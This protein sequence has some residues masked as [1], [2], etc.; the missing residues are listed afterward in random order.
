VLGAIIVAYFIGLPFYLWY[1]IYQVNKMFWDK[2]NTDKSIAIVKTPK[3]TPKQDPKYEPRAGGKI[4][5]KPVVKTDAN[6]Y[7]L[8][9]NP[10]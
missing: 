10:Q 3:V 7:E 5:F 8:E 4:K 1:C 9:N 2:R 6:L